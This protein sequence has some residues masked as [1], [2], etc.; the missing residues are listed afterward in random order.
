MRPLP[1]FVLAAILPFAGIATP[2]DGSGPRASADEERLVTSSPPGIPGGRVVVALRAEQ[3]APQRIGRRGAIRVVAG[4]IHD[5]GQPVRPAGAP[6][7]RPPAPKADRACLISTTEL[8]TRT[9]SSL[10]KATSRSPS[11]A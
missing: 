1:A 4:A 7:A 2:A 8:R 11:R 10:R 3:R 6:D 5:R 9:A